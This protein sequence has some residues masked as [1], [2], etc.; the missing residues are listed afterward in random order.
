MTLE[1]KI[2]LATLENNLC[3]DNLISS[4]VNVFLF[5]LT[6][7]TLPH[8]LFI[9]SSL[10]SLLCSM[11]YLIKLFRHILHC[12]SMNTVHFTFT[13]QVLRVNVEKKQVL[14]TNKR[15][16]VNTTQ[17]IPASYADLSPG[18]QLEGFIVS[19]NNKGVVVHFLNNVKVWLFSSLSFYV[20]LVIKIQAHCY[21]WKFDYQIAQMCNCY[22]IGKVS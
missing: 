14:L 21:C 16:L 4:Y 5:L 11:Y 13:P 22:F 18:Q 12:D 6:P 17:L 8:S 20:V 19:V 2:T 3:W 15:S 7:P 9:K 1:K 10:V